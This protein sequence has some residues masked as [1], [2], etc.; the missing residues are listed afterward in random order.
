MCG[1]PAC[2]RQ[3]RLHPSSSGCFPRIIKTPSLPTHKHNAGHNAPSHFA[4]RGVRVM[5]HPPPPVFVGDAAW[6]TGLVRAG[7]GPGWFKQGFLRDPLGPLYHW[8]S[9]GGRAQ[10]EPFSSPTRRPLAQAAAHAQ[11]GRASAWLLRVAA[12]AAAAGRRRQ[13]GL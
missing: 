1:S 11:P 4:L 12:A 5:M 8:A 2:R 9:L 6:G 7:F 3:Q 10:P 13:W